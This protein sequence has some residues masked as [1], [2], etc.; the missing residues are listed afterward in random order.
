MNILITGGTGLIGQQLIRQLMK[1]NANI[2]VLTRSKHK[3]KQVLPHEITLIETLSLSDVENQDSII[4]LA[5]EPI[6]DKRWSAPQK[7]RI[8]NSRWQITKQ[9]TSLISQ[10]E[11]PPAVFISGSAIGVYGRQ[12]QSIDESF[13]QYHQEFTHE[14][15]KKWEALA[16]AAQSA[17]TRVAIL[18][19]GI[20]LS[21]D[22]GA[23]GKMLLP[24]K[25]GLGGKIGAGQQ[26]MS[27]IHID[28]MVAAILYINK[29]K[30]LSGVIN[31]TAQ[32][33]V[34]N[35][36]FSKTLADALN[37]PCIITTPTFLLKLL[38]GE[39]AD[40]LLFGQHV[41]P[42]KLLESGF[43]FAYPKLNEALKNIL[44]NSS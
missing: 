42:K 34:T 18:R 14:V 11:K 31:V 36:E 20:V 3:A 6:A 17:N 23:L 38:L 16:T 39:M 13:T 35:Q 4:N 28:D 44:H 43:I 5:G 2:T 33:P 37:K 21:K 9:L 8:C 24:F 7:S 41:V 26:V 1:Q 32:N 30:Q 15:C 19:T 40:L 27:W 12:Q 29:T 25:L 22:G 10:A